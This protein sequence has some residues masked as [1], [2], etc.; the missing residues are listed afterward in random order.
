MAI[1]SL[2]NIAK[3]FV[4]SPGGTVVIKKASFV[5][6]AGETCSMIGPSGCGKSTLLHII[7]LLERPS[8]GVLKIDGQ[9]CSNLSDSEATQIRSL[10]IGFVYQAHNLLSEFTAVENIMIPLLINN[11][12]FKEARI[13]ALELLE[14]FNL[15]HRADNLST[16]LSG[17]EQQRVAIARAL[18][19]KPK[20]LLAD[21]PTGNLDE[22]NAEMVFSQFLQ[23]AKETKVAVLMVTHNLEL[24][25]K[26][27]R[28]L[29]IDK[30]FV[31]AK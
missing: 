30:G 8:S 27:D 14:S 22:Q 23:V 2:K 25:K 31:E 16:E 19:N 18:V 26:T 6:K 17:G 29:N 11:I 21:E 15:S 24:A 28:I 13:R 9:D 5:L 10:K 3:E 1:L 7:G 4:S 20:L 12:S